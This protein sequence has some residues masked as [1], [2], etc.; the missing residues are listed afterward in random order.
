MAW[1]RP[2]ELRTFL[3]LTAGHD[4]GPLFRLAAASGMRRG[5]LVGLRWCD[6]DLDRGLINVRRQL[7]S[8]D[9]L[10]LWDEPKT[11][12]GRRIITLD[13][14]TVA[15]LNEMQRSPSGQVF[16]NHAGEPPHPESVS[17]IFG[18]LVARSGLPRIRFHDVRHSHVAHLIEEGVDALTI[19]RRLGHASAAFTLD[20]YGHLFDQAGAT[21]AELLGDCWIPE[22][23]GDHRISG[24]GGTL[25]A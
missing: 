13:V 25:T 15:V 4:L 17:R 21:A 10:L 5:E 3:E 16:V 23:G 12:R 2:G 9:Y 22:A 18:R 14:G 1:W 11:D 20:R 7:A 24:S 8:T 19:S 6:V